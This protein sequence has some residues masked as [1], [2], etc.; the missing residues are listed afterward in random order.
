MLSK[1]LRGQESFIT[2]CAS[3][4]ARTLLMNSNMSLVSVFGGKT[5]AT[6]THVRPGSSVSVDVLFQQISRTEKKKNGTMQ[7]H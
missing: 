3:E 4:G 1:V 6:L 5:L 7:D 2:F